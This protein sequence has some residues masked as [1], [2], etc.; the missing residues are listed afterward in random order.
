MITV[1]IDEKRELLLAL[2][3]ASQHMNRFVFLTPESLTR[4]EVQ[5]W[6]AELR[7]QEL[8]VN[9]WGC[10]D[11][12]QFTRKGRAHYGPMIAAMRRLP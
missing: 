7:S 12:L 5:E 9:P 6:L 11:M 1:D 2:D 8:V 3:D 4:P 10:S